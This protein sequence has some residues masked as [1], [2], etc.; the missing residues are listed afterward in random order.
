MECGHQL[1]DIG[2]PLSATASKSSA[3]NRMPLL[4]LALVLASLHL[5]YIWPSPAW[6]AAPRTDLVMVDD[7][8]T[9]ARVGLPQSLPRTAQQ[10]AHGTT[11]RSA[12]GTLIVGTLKFGRDRELGQLHATLS[13]LSGRRIDKDSYEPG[14]FFELAGVDTDGSRFLVR[15]EQRQADLR[16]LSVTYSSANTTVEQTVQHIAASFQAFPGRSGIASRNEAGIN[17]TACSDRVARLKSFTEGL[18]V[19]LK[20]PPE[21]QEGGRIE[22]SW[23]SAATTWPVADT[24]AFL[25]LAMPQ[26]TRFEQV[27]RTHEIVNSEF[28]TRIAQHGPGFLALPGG[29]RAP[30]DIAFRREQVR[31]FVPLSGEEAGFV[32][33]FKIKPYLIGEYGVTW[34]IVAKTPCGETRLT[35]E[36]TTAFRVK[37]GTPRL[38]VEDEADL[39][40]PLKTELSTNGRFRLQT[41]EGAYRVYDAQ[42]DRLLLERSGRNARFSKTARFLVAGVRQDSSRHFS[43]LID[44]EALELVADSFPENV[45][46]SE[47][48][49]VSLWFGTRGISPGVQMVIAPLIDVDPASPLAALNA[50]SPLRR[51][52]FGFWEPKEACSAC[53]RP[54]VH[55]DLDTLTVAYV[56]GEPYKPNPYMP[57]K[58]AYPYAAVGLTSHK[59]DCCDTLGGLQASLRQRRSRLGPLTA[60]QLAPEDHEMATWAFGRAQEGKAGPPHASLFAGVGAPVN[61]PNA[62]W[63]AAVRS[64]P[65]GPDEEEAPSAQWDSLQAVGIVPK[66][67]LPISRLI[68]L[69]DIDRETVNWED[70]ES[71]ATKRREEAAPSA[72]QLISTLFPD[73]GSRL[74]E[75]GACTAGIFD[76]VASGTLDLRFTDQIWSWSDGTTKMA[77]V[78]LS[79]EAGQWGGEKSGSLTLMTRVGDQPSEVVALTNKDMQ[80]GSDF[81]FDFQTIVAPVVSEDGWLSLL[82]ESGSAAL[83][84]KLPACTDRKWLKDLQQV[85]GTKSGLRLLDGTGMLQLNA[86]GQF[87]VYSLQTGKWLLQ[88]R[89]VDNEAVVWTPDL[90]YDAT[91]EGSHMVNLRF[92]GRPGVYTFHQFESELRVAGL[93]EKIRAGE[94]LTAKTLRVPPVLSARLQLRRPGRI[95]AAG[96]IEADEAI[97]A[98]YVY[99]DGVLTDTINQAA[100][101]SQFDLD[102]ARRPGARWVS[103]VGVSA[104]G[105]VSQPVGKDLGPDAAGK[106]RLHVFAVGVGDYKDPQIPDLPSAKLDP[107]TIIDALQRGSASA[108]AI[109]PPKQ[110]V[111]ASATRA[112]ILSALDAALADVAAGDTLLFAYSGHGVRVNGEYYLAGH[113][114]LLNDVPDTAIAWPEIA[115][116]LRSSSARIVLL[117]DACHSGS[118]GTELFATNDAAAGSILTHIPSNV[119]VFAASKGRELSYESLTVRGGVFSAAFADVVA[120]ERPEHDTNRNGVIE[121]SELFV[122]IKR[123]VLI[124]G[125]PVRAAVAKREGRSEVGT[126]TPWIARNKMLGDFA[127]F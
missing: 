42:T 98:V 28:E 62:E 46:W 34:A 43:E 67:D 77:L 99:Q 9:G 87:F 35:E 29:A 51:K 25:V 68:D 26:Q 90:A 63:R 70:Y 20:A 122:A 127:L 109:R 11:W 41:F 18:N 94:S 53:A 115:K 66:K 14:K 110:L 89:I 10:T 48:D 59:V 33:S 126:Q 108:L 100:G 97:S 92:A 69:P 15:V 2:A 79:S 86:D 81:T 45:D 78:Q 113:D 3:L 117:L 73:L 58:F 118:A 6:S 119:V 49:A 40:Q 112:G 30:H 121:V 32:S 125:Y 120:N 5:E 23:S 105:L 47:G 1:R 38:I 123:K 107:A 96:T 124:D 52:V 37:S 7:V 75:P 21:L 88:G 111:D 114:T 71:E 84:C 13:R 60:K 39:S 80:I 19:S 72:R 17:R 50:L 61:A 56:S 36:T 91:P 103:L 95:A 104:S 8:A 24:P 16:G 31:A 55:L 12:D 83:I 106:A 54:I 85:S 27:L 65:G 57:E 4:L 102:I 93:A 101:A 116:R 82:F 64:A 74:P 22:V 44:L 76:C